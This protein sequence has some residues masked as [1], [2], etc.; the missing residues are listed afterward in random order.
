MKR[1]TKTIALRLP[2]SLYRQVKRA[3][4]KEETVSDVVRRLL[5]SALTRGGKE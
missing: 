3:Q 4:A 2:A 1:N 5:A